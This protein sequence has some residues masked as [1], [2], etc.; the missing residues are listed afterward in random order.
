MVYEYGSE[1][2]QGIDEH[3]AGELF[4]AVASKPSD[5]DLHRLVT[6]I[7]QTRQDQHGYFIT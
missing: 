3:L 7:E 5:P 4:M 6:D 1:T 2:R